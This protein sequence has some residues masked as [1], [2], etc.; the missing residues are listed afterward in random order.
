MDRNQQDSLIIEAL[1]GLVSNV[2]NVKK[3]VNIGRGKRKI[4]PSC[5]FENNF[6]NMGYLG[7]LYLT[8]KQESDRL[9]IN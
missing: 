6:V 1:I 4:C 3:H 5:F 2:R 8:F 9:G 7:K